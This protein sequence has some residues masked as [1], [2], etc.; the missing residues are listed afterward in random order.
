MSTWCSEPLAQ[1]A[2]LPVVA[3]LRAQ[4][5]SHFA[6]F[7]DDSGSVTAEF[8]IAL[9]AALLVLGV[10]VGA[11][12]LA[13]EKVSLTAGAAE[14][15][16]HEARG[17][18]ALAQAQL[19]KLGA[20]ITVSRTDNGSLHCVTLSSRPATGVLSLLTV[21]SFSCAARATLTSGTNESNR[22]L[23]TRAVA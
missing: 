19:R 3:R 16:R 14:I 15:A 6:A 8:A 17:D 2:K 1:P 20:H 23:L 11:I 13:A 5:G 21:S 9:P 12:V 22:D 18:T 10:S 4:I 7:A